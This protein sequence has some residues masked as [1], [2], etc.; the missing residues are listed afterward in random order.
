MAPNHRVVGSL[1]KQKRVPVIC[2][3]DGQLD[4]AT[5]GDEEVRQRAKE[6]LAVTLSLVRQLEAYVLEVLS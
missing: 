6:Q 2:S 4:E 5:N 3:V 1:R